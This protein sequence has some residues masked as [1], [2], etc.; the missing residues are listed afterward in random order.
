MFFFYE[1]ACKI[2]RKLP[3][4][5]I[6]IFVTGQQEVQ[7]LCK[8]FRNTFPLKKHDG[9]KTDGEKVEIKIENKKKKKKLN[10]GSIKLDSVPKVNL[11]KYV[12]MFFYYFIRVGTW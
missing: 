3:E 4:G 8:K 6:L 2:H 5:G 1:K 10:D 12:E 9:E 7:V 11:D